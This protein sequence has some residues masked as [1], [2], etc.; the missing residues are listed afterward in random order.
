MSHQGQ[1]PRAKAQRTIACDFCGAPFVDYV[2]NH[3]KY[4][5]VGCAIEA[6]KGGRRNV[7]SWQDR[8]WSGVKRLGKNDCWPWQRGRNKDGY[9]NIRIG[10]KMEKAH[11]AAFMAGRSICIPDGMLVCHKCDCPPCCNPRHLFLGTKA[12]NN[13]DKMK[14]GRHRA[15]HGEEHPLAKVN[16]GDVGNIR[17]STERAI[18]LASQYGLDV[19]SIR[20]IRSGRSW[21]EKRRDL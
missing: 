17:K 9:G 15:L 18:V 19:S 3:R 16:W 13:A 5:S 7:R 11:R 12:E 2:S 21:N 20:N 14:K 8:L 1:T 10:A 6:R 4:C